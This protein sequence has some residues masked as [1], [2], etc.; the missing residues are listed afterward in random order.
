[1]LQ[2]TNLTFAYS[3]SLELQFPDFD[4]EDGNAL[5]LSG[6][7]GCGK[8]T[9]LHLLAGLR[10][11]KSGQIVIDGQQISGLS[12]VQM[13]QFRGLHIGLIHQQSHFIQ[14]LSVLDNIMLAPHARDKAKA[15]EVAHRLQITDDLLHRRPNQLSSGQQQRVTIARAVINTPK[16]ILADEPTSALD[17][18]NCSKVIDL[19]LQEASN[20]NATL[21]I[22]THDDRLKQE[23]SHRIELSPLNT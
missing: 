2:A 21:L 13:D 6:E 23:I 4:V 17:N 18:K 11:P 3:D 15:K 14:S 19:L 10:K 22:A 20:H 9:L 12:Q 8:T 5:L 1:M 16:L 7:S